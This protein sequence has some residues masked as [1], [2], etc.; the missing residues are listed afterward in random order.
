M[1]YHKDIPHY[2]GCLIFRKPCYSSTPIPIPEAP[3]LDHTP[4]ATLPNSLC[5]DSCEH[6]V[7]RPRPLSP[8]YPK[9]EKGSFLLEYV[10]SHTPKSIKRTV[11]MS[12][13]PGQ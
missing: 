10:Q 4:D 3:H 8:H 9:K 2:R 11:A 7:E 6:C 12:D 1:L 13:V 5:G